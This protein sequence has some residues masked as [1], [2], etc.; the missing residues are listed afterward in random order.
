[1]L[2]GIGMLEGMTRP[3]G[4]GHGPTPPSPVGR[5]GPGGRGP[6][7]VAGGVVAVSV[8]AGGLGVVGVAAAVAAGPPSASDRSFHRLT[9]QTTLSIIKSTDCHH[10][11]A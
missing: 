7:G 10:I 9:G 8:G 6:G 11:A 1:M 5:G 3:D 2:D 4:T